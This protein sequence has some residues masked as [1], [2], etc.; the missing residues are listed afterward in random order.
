M[1]IA[2]QAR[3]YQAVQ[4]ASVLS[5][6]ETARTIHLLLERAVQVELVA[7][8]A[9]THPALLAVSMALEGRITY[10]T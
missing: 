4:E 1:K 5:E 2:L 7:L 9:T 3:E 10:L 6:P 8:E